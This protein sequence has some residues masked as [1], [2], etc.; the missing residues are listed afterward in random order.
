V[1]EFV[2]LFEF[3][4]RSGFLYPG[5]AAGLER[6]LTAIEATWE[7]LLAAGTDVFHHIE[8]RCPEDLAVSNSI[9]AFRYAPGT[10]QAQ[11]LVS[12]Q[13]HEYVGT[14]T[15]LMALVQWL[16]DSGARFV[17]LTFRPNNRGANPLFGGVGELMPRDLVNVS[18]VDYG[19]SPVAGVRVAE[20][21]AEVRVGRSD[22]L[23]ARRFYGEL[24]PPVEL[25]SLALRDP[26]F[27]ELDP[28]YG[29]H[30]L[31]RRRH[32]YVASVGDRVVG[33][34]LVHHSSEGMNFSFLENA[35]EYLR[36]APDLPSRLRARVWNALLRVAVGDVGRQRDYVVT[37]TDPG[38]RDL[39]VAS[40][41]V[42][43]DPP[44]QYAVLTVSR[45]R[46]ALLLANRHFAS[47]YKALLRVQ[48]ETA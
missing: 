34:C 9:C 17:R 33:A 4:R 19:I 43:V 14:L 24:L 15:V 1:V 38:D 8:R 18:V 40:G 41:L 16:H 46:D 2:E 6:R 44:K 7:R 42:G 13:R 3:Y 32:V 47:Y 23:Q 29:R 39:A 31:S 21:D 48:A 27:S 36:V 45:E 5:K 37:T 30:G 12:G 26:G 28:I 22:D 11:H 35:I 25:A 20:A 10:W